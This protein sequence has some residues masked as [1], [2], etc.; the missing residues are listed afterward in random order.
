MCFNRRKK[1]QEPDPEQEIF[2]F[3]LPRISSI[4]FCFSICFVELISSPTLLTRTFY[5]CRDAFSTYE[6]ELDNFRP[7]VLFSCLFVFCFLRQV[8]EKQKNK[9]KL[10]AILPW[11]DNTYN[12]IIYKLSYARK[13]SLAM[14][15]REF[16]PLIR[17]LLWSPPW[18]CSLRFPKLSEM[19]YVPYV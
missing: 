6:T 18:S 13:R 2:F 9:R 19:S 4:L 15:L 12:E 14:T 17:L 1:S 5:R 11:L 16:S 3:A 7:K 10:L 8:R